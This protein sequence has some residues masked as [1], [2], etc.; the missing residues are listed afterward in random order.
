MFLDSKSDSFEFTFPKIFFPSDIKQ[1]YEGYLNRIPGY[2]VDNLGDFINETVQSVT[3]NGASFEPVEQSKYRGRNYNFRS[4]NPNQELYNKEFTVSMRLTEGF[5]NYWVMLD[6]LKHYYKFENTNH[7][8]DGIVLRTLDIEGHVIST[9]RLNE[10]IFTG[11]S[12]LSFSF[13]ATTPQ[14]NEFECSFTFNDLDL[15]IEL[16]GR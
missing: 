5:I 11:I 10:C 7:F 3:F 14:F 4:S 9:L 12:D 16:D 1:K 2:P 15:I 6:L 13:A 8:I